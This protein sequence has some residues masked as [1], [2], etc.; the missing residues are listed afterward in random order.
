MINLPPPFFTGAGKALETTWL[1][2]IEWSICAPGMV[3]VGN[4]DWGSVTM[5]NQVVGHDTSKTNEGR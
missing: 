3:S 1:V 4:F 5:V 2:A